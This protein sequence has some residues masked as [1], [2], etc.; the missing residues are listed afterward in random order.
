MTTHQVIGYGGIPLFVREEGPQDAPPILLIHGWSQHHLSW[1]K[2][3]ES[4]LT[5]DFRLIAP[6]LRGHGASGKPEEPEAYNHSRPWADD[7]AAI[8]DELD[9]ANPI[10]VGWSMG[11]DVIC[12]Y[13]R[14]HG[15]SRISGVAFV[16][17]AI[18]AMTEE[19]AS[20]PARARALSTW[21][22]MCSK[23]PKAAME[24]TIA[25]LKSCV[26]APLSKQ[27]LAFMTGLNALCPPPIRAHML[28]RT[29]DYRPD[30]EG[31][32][33]PAMIIYGTAEK[34]CPPEL[35]REAAAAMPHAWTHAYSGTGHCPFW[36]KPDRFNRHL[37]EFARETLGVA[38]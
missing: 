5:Q 16:G 13:L 19:E 25:F 17:G 33:I 22:G 4:V 18:R 11:T 8:I 38:A 23:N 36:E 7:I 14:V 29:E 15:P 2:Q 12:D 31:I 21:K 34:V 26:A 35:V 30:L 3:L 10:L 32:E 24:A 9:L 1:T 27:D 28:S 37:A 20:I 6:D